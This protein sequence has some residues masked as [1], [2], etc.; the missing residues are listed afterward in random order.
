M[1][2]I[3]IERETQEKSSQKGRSLGVLL[4][5]VL[6]ILPV[7][8]YTNMVVRLLDSSEKAM[9]FHVES[10]LGKP[11]TQG[12]RLQHGTMLD[13]RFN[14]NTRNAKGQKPPWGFVQRAR[15]FLPSDHWMNPI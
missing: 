14:L 1:G 5:G 4:D 11:P 2:C 12:F 9:E 10:K 3:R 15:A 8:G 6:E 7:D 13:D